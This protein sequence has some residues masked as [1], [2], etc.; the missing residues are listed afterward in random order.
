MFISS[1]SFECTIMEEEMQTFLECH[2]FLLD[3]YEF[4]FSFLHG[5]NLLSATVMGGEGEGPTFFMSLY[6][7][8]A[9]FHLRSAH[10]SSKCLTLARL[11]QG[12]WHEP[13]GG[14]F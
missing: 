6:A 5:E 4:E 9:M 13:V 12:N 2:K 3:N 14:P 11:C 8:E 7:L 10:S 1:G